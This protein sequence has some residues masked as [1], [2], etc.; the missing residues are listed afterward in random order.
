MYVCTYIH[1]CMYVYANAIHKMILQ[2]I[3]RFP[4]RKQ[5]P[6]LQKPSKALCI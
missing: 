2:F 5:P 1:V 3:S 4:L 6:L